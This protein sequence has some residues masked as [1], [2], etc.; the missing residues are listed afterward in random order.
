MDT[1]LDQGSSGN[2]DASSAYMLTNLVDATMAF[3]IIDIHQYMV[4]SIPMIL[5]PSGPS[6]GVH[7]SP[8]GKKFPARIFCFF[9]FSII[10]EI[11]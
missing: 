5:Q 9:L 10:S 7:I 8:E 11:S 1:I 3:R 2:E 4:E 6:D